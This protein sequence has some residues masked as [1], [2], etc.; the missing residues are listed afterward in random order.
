MKITK[1]LLPRKIR[2]CICGEFE[3]NRKVKVLFVYFV[4]FTSC[5]QK[6]HVRTGPDKCSRWFSGE[7]TLEVPNDEKR[8]IQRCV[9]HCRYKIIDLLELEH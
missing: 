2:F 3:V 1:V 4:N 5:E 6:S 7:K 8:E 9:I